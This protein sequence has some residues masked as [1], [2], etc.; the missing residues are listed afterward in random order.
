M[1]E[2]GGTRCGEAKTI[3]AGDLFERDVLR[4]FSNCNCHGMTHGYS[5]W[6]MPIEGFPTKAFN[7][8][9]SHKWAGLSIAGTG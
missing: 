1:L 5:S 2:V 8:V 4:H 6:L 9:A 3:Q 7:D